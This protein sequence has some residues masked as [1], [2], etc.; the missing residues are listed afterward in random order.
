MGVNQSFDIAQEAME[1]ILRNLHEVEIY[2]DDVDCFSTDL[3]WVADFHTLNNEDSWL[4]MNDYKEPISNS[5]LMII[6]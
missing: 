5:A 6:R 4:S 1:S 2:I 3:P